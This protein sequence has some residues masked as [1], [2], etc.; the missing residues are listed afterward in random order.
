MDAEF[1]QGV[2][3][4]GISRPRP[5][6]FHRGFFVALGE[7]GQS[8][9]EFVILFPLLLGM[10][11]LL[12][13]MN[14]VIQVSIVN[15]KYARLQTHFLTFNSP[16]FPS[17]ATGTAGDNRV[18]GM[19]HL[20]VGVGDEAIGPGADRPRAVEVFVGRSP[21]AVAGASDAANSEPPLRAKVRV[22]TTVSLCSFSHT[23]SG[24]ASFSE[25]DRLRALDVQGASRGDAASIFNFCNWGEIQ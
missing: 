21:A 16:Y 3:K 15:Q 20:T 14:S 17:R 25:A 4:G 9:F 13:R 2:F 5:A 11:A 1:Y 10:T 18:T 6:A 22:R 19:H 8:I 7:E 12:I 23:L 24:G